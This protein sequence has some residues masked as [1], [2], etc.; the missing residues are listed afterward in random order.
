MR[1]VTTPRRPAP[2]RC[3]GRTVAVLDLKAGDVVLD[4][5]W[6]TGLSFGLLLEG[7]GPTG[8]VVASSFPPRLLAQCAGPR[9][10]ERLGERRF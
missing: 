4:L 10:I 8:T 3:G 6:R 5:A 9:K 7:V 2:W 1:R